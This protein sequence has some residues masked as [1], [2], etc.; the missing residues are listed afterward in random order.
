MSSYYKVLATANNNVTTDTIRYE[1]DMIERITDVNTVRNFASE[2]G[3][4]IKPYVK[5]ELY[6]GTD[7]T[8]FK[9]QT[10]TLVQLLVFNLKQSAKIVKRTCDYDNSDSWFWLNDPF[11]ACTNP[12]GI[13][14][15]ENNFN[16]S[17]YFSQSP[18]F[19]ESSETY[20]SK[21]FRV[22][23]YQNLQWIDKV[24]C[25][26]WETCSKILDNYIVPAIDPFEC[27]ND[28]TIEYCSILEDT[29][30]SNYSFNLF[31]IASAS[32]WDGCLSG[33]EM[34]FY[35]EGY[36]NLAQ[37]IIDANL[38]SLNDYSWNI[39][40]GYLNWNGIFGG[41]FSFNTYIIYWR[42]APSFY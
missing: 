37:G 20:V 25:D 3:M 10:K 42:C 34:N 1:V 24:P 36:A 38:Y 29:G 5:G 12:S 15:L 8:M 41:P 39:Y 31:Y 35:Q 9:G 32:G 18:L 21:A 6:Q 11:S 2:V 13:L 19:C 16:N 28:P 30:N 7:V 17:C 22:A 23:P 40:R 26:S 33:E 14:D 27:L 4:L